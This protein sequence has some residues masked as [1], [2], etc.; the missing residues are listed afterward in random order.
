[1]DKKNRLGRGLEA[2]IPSNETKNTENLTKYIDI[3]TIETNPDQPRKYFNDDS[4]N[5]LAESIKLHGLLQ[6]IILNKIENNKFKLIA[7][8]RRLRASKKA[9]FKQILSIIQDSEAQKQF[10][11]A[12][13]ENI[14]REDLSP[15]EEASA[16]KKLIEEYGMTQ[17]K[18]AEKLSKSRPVISNA[19]RLLDLPIKIQNMLNENL[20]SAGHARL[21]LSIEDSQKYEYA[22]LVIM[23]QLSVRQLEK[24]ISNQNK[25]RINPNIK[26]TDP[27]I[28]QL[29]TKLIKVFGNSV[30]ITIN[31]KNI[32]SI[33]INFHSIDEF[34]GI[35]DKIDY[36]KEDE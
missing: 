9:G 2:L 26:S 21:L 23:E 27:E 5:K 13:I 31:R 17:E 3:E 1:M 19:I 28:K 6:P 35:L 30:K 25:K 22:N 18:V 4:I 7:G 20:I 29:E 8:E 16:Y 33:K 14:Q 15:L 10:E 11:L 34:E 32:G 24:I 12:I 36:Q